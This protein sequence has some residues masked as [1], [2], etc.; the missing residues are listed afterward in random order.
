VAD[1]S[2]VVAVVVAA[3]PVDIGLEVLRNFA[4]AFAVLPALA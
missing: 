2:A 4:V 3:E 1:K